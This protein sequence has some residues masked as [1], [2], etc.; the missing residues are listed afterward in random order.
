[1]PF[2]TTIFEGTDR[3]LDIFPSSNV[4]QVYPRDEIMYLC[5]DETV[6]GI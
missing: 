6:C 1:M 3:S 2:K 5:L 4:E